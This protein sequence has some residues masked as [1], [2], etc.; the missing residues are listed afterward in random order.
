ME[1]TWINYTKVDQILK[2]MEEINAD[3]EN[4]LVIAQ[5]TSYSEDIKRKI[6]KSLGWQQEQR[7]KLKFEELNNVFLGEFAR[8]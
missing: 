4:Q 1:T 2:N 5:T 6:F 8:D 3:F 7:F